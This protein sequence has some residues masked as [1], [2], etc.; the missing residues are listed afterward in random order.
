[1]CGINNCPEQAGSDNTTDCCYVPVVG[2]EGFCASGIPCGEDEGDCDS[3]EE[4]ESELFCGSN[5]CPDSLG[6]DLEVDCCYNTTNTLISPNYPNIYPW[7]I[8]ED[9]LL[10]ADLGEIINLQFP[11]FSVS[12]LTTSHRGHKNLYCKSYGQS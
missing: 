2:E 3:N 8:D 6:F 4:C 7:M 11:S 9:W 1:M 10:T 5:N 12:F